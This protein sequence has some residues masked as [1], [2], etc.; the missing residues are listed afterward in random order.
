MANS[1]TT[2]PIVLDDF[3]SVID[4]ADVFPGKRKISLQAIEWAGPTTVGHTFQVLAGGANGVPIFDETCTV[5]DDSIKS[6]YNNCKPFAPLYLTA[7]SGNEKAS[8]KLLI[9]LK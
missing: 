5:A 6:D 2:N 8:G 9:F 4:F 1:F 7:A 3:S